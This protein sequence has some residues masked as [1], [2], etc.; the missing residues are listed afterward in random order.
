MYFGIFKVTV[1]ENANVRTFRRYFS[2]DQSFYTFFEIFSNFK[3]DAFCQLQYKQVT[4]KMSYS[5]YVH[6]F[7]KEVIA[8]L[9]KPLVSPKLHCNNL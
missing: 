6:F 8:N 4:D 3:L 5:K 7:T 2:D 1:V 9:A